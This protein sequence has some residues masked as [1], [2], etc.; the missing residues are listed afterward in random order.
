MATRTAAQRAQA[1]LDW[2]AKPK[3]SGRTPPTSIDPP[4]ARSPARPTPAQKKTIERAVEQHR[5]E[6]AALDREALEALAPVFAQA[7]REL[8]AALLDAIQR[9]P[10]GELR[11]TA[12]SYR[13][14]LAQI[15]EGSRVLG[16]ALGQ[17]LGD[18]TAAAQQLAVRH[19]A[20]DLARF[21]SEFTGSLRPVH[22][23]AAKAIATGK[24]FIIPRI[25]RSAERYQGKVREDIQQRLAVDILKGATVRETT[26]RLVEHGGPRGLVNLG[27]ADVE[28]IP[29]GLFARYRYWAERVVRTE[30]ASAYGSATVESLDEARRQV[31]GLKKLWMASP[32]CCATICY[33]IDGQVV[34]VEAKFKTP[35]GPVDHSPAHPNCRCTVSGW[36]DAWGAAPHDAVPDDS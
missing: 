10:D 5:R 28:D 18:T 9:M 34:E 6:V 22:L 19:V 30:N 4:G 33:P 16:E 2:L 31:P 15:R 17:T 24:S 32:K 11:W 21:S 35:L 1:V 12:Q 27:G 7:E 14:V 26:N 13:A 3:N 25:A 8:G 29:E 36:S 23:D 20:R